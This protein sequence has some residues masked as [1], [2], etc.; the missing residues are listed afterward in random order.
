MPAR[1]REHVMK[2]YHTLALVCILPGCRY[3]EWGK[4]QFQQAD[5][6]CDYVKPVKPYIRSMDLFDGFSTVGHFDVLLVAEPVRQAYT[7]AF[8]YRRGM[9]EEKAR[10]FT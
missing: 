5:K 9:S 3:V 2:W 4:G 7:K 6:W 10:E 8:A 1:E